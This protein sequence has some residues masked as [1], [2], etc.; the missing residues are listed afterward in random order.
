MILMAK[1]KNLRELAK[2]ELEEGEGVVIDGIENIDI[3]I[4]PD[5]KPKQKSKFRKKL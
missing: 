2:I 5:E 4:V 1:L 3:R